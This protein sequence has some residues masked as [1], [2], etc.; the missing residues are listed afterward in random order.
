MATVQTINSLVTR[1]RQRSDQIGSDTFDDETELKP[2]IR[3][4]LAQLH[5]ILCQRAVD[6][7]TTARPLSLIAGQEA[8]SLPSD[9]KQLQD[10]FV[11]YNGGQSR[12]QMRN[13]SVDEFG[14]LN[15]PQFHTAPLRYR[16]MR[17]LIY[18]QPVPTFDAFNALE[19]YYTPQYRPPLLDYTPIDE[20]LPDGWEE[21]AVLDVIQ[22]MSIKTRLQNMDDILKSKA[23]MEARLIAGASIRDG[24]APVMRDANRRL[25]PYGGGRPSGPLVWAI[26]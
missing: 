1:I 16:L 26:T 2:W 13:F 22:K 18:I 12:Q 6:Y 7:Y 24:F 21:W 8:Y 14:A 23:Q 9:F 20:V 10:I 17:N 25:R 19:M 4:S 3:G 15:A 5:E 11:L